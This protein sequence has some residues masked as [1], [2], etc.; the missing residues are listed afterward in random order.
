MKKVWKKGRKEEGKSTEK[1]W[2]NGG[3]N[4]EG[5]KNLEL[6]YTMILPLVLKRYGKRAEGVWNDLF[7]VLKSL[8]FPGGFQHKHTQGS[9]I[10]QKKCGK[11]MADVRK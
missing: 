9:G 7:P 11:A 10:V 4:L 8:G 1:R 2:Q 3:R 6:L 5:V